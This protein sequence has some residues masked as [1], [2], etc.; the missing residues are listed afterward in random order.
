MNRL[1]IV[2]G[3]VLLAG[4]APAA[5][6]RPDL[7]AR[8]Q[9]SVAPPVCFDKHSRAGALVTITNSGGADAGP[10]MVEVNDVWQAVPDGLK[11]GASK[12]IWFDARG[13]GSFWA[14]MAVR[15][16]PA[17]QVAESDETNN[18]YTAPVMTLTPPLPCP[19]MTPAPTVTA[20]H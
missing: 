12:S 2:L 17:D 1:R 14:Q 11:A 15:V 8:A 6:A 10:F 9:T 20:A 19:T 4:C 13:F 5:L 3:L 16:D 18:T 7:S